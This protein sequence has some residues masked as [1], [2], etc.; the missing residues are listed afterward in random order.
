MYT[1]IFVEDKL[2]ARKGLINMIDWESIGFQVIDEADYDEVLTIIKDKLSRKRLL[3][4]QSST[5]MGEKLVESLIRGDITE[6]DL[7]SWQLPWTGATSFTYILVEWNNLILPW[8]IH[9][10]PPKDMLAT[11][12]RE[13]VR[14]AAAA[15]SSEPLMFVHRNAFGL[16]I[17]DLYLIPSNE[18]MNDFLK[19]LLK[20][21]NERFAL[22]FRVYAGKPVCS[23]LQLKDS[24]N[25]AKEA[26]QFKYLKHA[27]DVIRYRDIEGMELHYYILEDDVLQKLMDAVEENDFKSLESSMNYM[28]GEFQEKNFAPEAMK[29]AIMQYVQRILRTV[30]NLGGDERELVNL[31]V[32]M[33]WHD[34][35]ITVDV[36]RQIVI[37]FAQEASDM[38]SLLQQTGK[39]G[40]HQVRRYIDENYNRNINLKGIANHFYMNSAYL[41][42]LF[43]KNYGVYFNEY[44]VQLRIKAAKELLRQTDMRNYE[45]A[46][47]V[48]FNNVDYFVSMFEKLEQMTPKEYRN[49]INQR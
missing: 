28:F 19:T 31:N 42:Q 4:D 25:S 5:L 23:L 45:I 17:P 41:G 40:I 2:Y 9:S 22:H 26:M 35:N 10:M 32:V 44:V 39:G 7:E 29:S 20:L 14:Q 12:V 1:I 36:L 38:I 30:R 34:Q 49:R 46:A 6:T 18:S 47:Q 3:R 8:S 21:L 43:K 33:G 24:Y 27:N 11:G 16:I 48:G 13:C 15:S 37:A